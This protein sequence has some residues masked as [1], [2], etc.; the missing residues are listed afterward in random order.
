MISQKRNHQCSISPS[1]GSTSVIALIDVGLFSLP[2]KPVERFLNTRSKLIGRDSI[3]V[4]GFI[5]E[6][7]VNEL[8]S[9]DSEPIIS[10]ATELE[11]DNNCSETVSCVDDL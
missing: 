2:T 11:A 7:D 9:C 6:L 10:P 1:S 3:D 4:A 5:I 8:N